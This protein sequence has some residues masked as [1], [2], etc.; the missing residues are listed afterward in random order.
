MN[1]GVHG[2]TGVLSLSIELCS[3]FT[4]RSTITFWQAVKQPL[5]AVLTLSKEA[6]ASFMLS[7]LTM[8]TA[9]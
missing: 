6:V 1:K 7:V 2:F 8:S 5:R 9:Q 3:T 4:Y